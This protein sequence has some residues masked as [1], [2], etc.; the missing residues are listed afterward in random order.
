MQLYTG[1]DFHSRNTYICTIDK[2]FKRAF[3][4]RASKK[5][6]KD[7]GHLFKAACQKKHKGLNYWLITSAF[8][9][10]TNFCLTGV[11]MIPERSL[12][13]YLAL[14]SNDMRKATN[15]LSIFGLVTSRA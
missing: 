14:G 8:I 10:A 12:R 9:A 1:F 2:E 5:N 4:K 13:V 3:G 7:D 15:G 6:G 11:G